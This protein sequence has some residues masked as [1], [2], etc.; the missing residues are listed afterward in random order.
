MAQDCFNKHIHYFKYGILKNMAKMKIQT[1]SSYATY[2][3]VIVGSS[4]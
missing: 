3:C 1:K 4:T 2:S